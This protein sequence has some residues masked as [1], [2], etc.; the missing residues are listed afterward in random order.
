VIPLRR[1]PVGSTMSSMRR[2][3]NAQVTVVAVA[4]AVT[5]SVAGV[6][7]SLW[8][9]ATAGGTVVEDA[10][11]GA[12]VIGFAVVGAVV[13]AARPENR[14]GWLMLAGATCWS[15]GQAGCDLAYLGIVARPG[16]VPLVAV[17]AN[18]GSAVRAI[19]WFTVTI[20]V[21]LVFPD[22]RLPGRRWRFLPWL[23]GVVLLSAVLDPLTDPQAGLLD[24]G[25]WQNPVPTAHWAGAGAAAFLATVPLGF[26]LTAAVVASLVVRWR[27]GDALV[28]QQILLLAAAAALTLAAIPVAFGTGIGWVFSAAALPLPFAIGFAVL[29]RGLYDLRT[30]ANRTLLW[31]T[32]SAVVATAYAVVIAGVGAMLHV[33]GAPWLPWVAAAAVAI[34]F[35]PLRDGLQRTVNRLTYGRWEEPYDVLAALGQRLEGSADVDRLLADVVAELAALG[36]QRVS[37]RDDR[38]RVLA[39]ASTDDGAVTVPLAAYGRT[40]GTLRYQPPQPPLRARDQQ[41]VDDLAGHLGGV[42]HAHRLTA[43]LSRARESLVLAREEERRRLR[44]DLHDGLGPALAGHLLRLD[45][46]AGQAVP[47]TLVADGVGALRADLRATVLEVRRVVEGLRPPAL[48]ELGLAG[49]LARATARLTAGSPVR[50]DLTVGELPPLPAAVEVAAYRIVT[51]AV[52]NVVRH[53]SAHV[54]TVRIDTADGVLRASVSDDG[55]GLPATEPTGHGLQTMRERAE[56]L[57]GRLSVS[58]HGG[59]TITAELPLPIAPRRSVESTR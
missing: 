22:G 48:D 7:V 38:G 53:A 54:C 58:G 3:P 57:R 32:L 16:S 18:A 8:A 9:T 45:V 29:A 23:L 37:V 19:G 50:A 55:A 39:G 49:A 46:L 44:R 26:L 51:E 25:D 1:A 4:A 13:A 14:V 43:D 27:R 6:A 11:S 15:L 59:T 30:A 52:T 40:L 28:R 17:W 47:G 21:P 34:S 33:R 20:G 10:L 31:V 36:L 12:V 42:L 35:A 56:E 2:L 24:L 5:A 41:L